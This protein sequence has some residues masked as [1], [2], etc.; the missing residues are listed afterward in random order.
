[1][2]F[3]CYKLGWLAGKSGVGEFSHTT[4][5]T[6]PLSEAAPE[7]FLLSEGARWLP[8]VAWENSPTPLSSQKDII[9]GLNGVA[10]ARHGLILWENG[11]TG[12]RKLSKCLW[13]L[14]HIIK[15]IKKCKIV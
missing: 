7:L 13:G 3:I 2:L 12:S 4:K 14:K 8:G 1:M 5:R 9:L 11:A 15:N 6:W 10:M